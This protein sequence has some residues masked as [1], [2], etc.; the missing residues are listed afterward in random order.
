V[1]IRVRRQTAGEVDAPTIQQLAAGRNSD[2]H[3]RVTVLGDTGGRVLHSRFRHVLLPSTLKIERVVP[4][5]LHA[6][7]RSHSCFVIRHVGKG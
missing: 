1:V 3:G 7:R 6:A 5:R 4:R 2:E